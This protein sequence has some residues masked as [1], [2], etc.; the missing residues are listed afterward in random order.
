[1]LE[2]Q[3]TEYINI[4]EII[5]FVRQKDYKFVEKLSRGGCGTTILLKDEVINELF[6]CKKYDPFDPEK[7]LDSE[8]KEKLF[9]NFKEEI[10]LL[11]LV[12]NKNIVRVFNYHIYNEY[13]TGYII[14]EYVKGINI[15][16][17]LAWFPENINDV[18]L[19][20]VDGFTYLEK[21]NILHRDV[22]PQN[23]MVTNDGQVKIIDFGFG[24]QIKSNKDFDKS[25]SLNWWCEPPLDFKQKTY[26]FKTELYFVGKLFEQI[27]Q[28][29]NIETFKY[30]YELSNMCKTNPEERIDS[31]A[32]IKQ[33]ILENQFLELPFSQ[34]E[35]SIYLDFANHLSNVIS[36]IK[37]S[38][39]Y[40][41]DIDK[42]Q[43]K[44]EELFKKVMLENV[45][46]KN[47][48]IIDCFFKGGYSYWKR[49]D[50]PIDSL[51]K[52]IEMLR[53]SS[54]EKKNVILS[55]LH[56]RFNAIER[57]KEDLI[58]EDEIPF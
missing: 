43:S 34:E 40:Y 5:K 24:K 32:N 50:F 52:I 38:T 36:K 47:T 25:I 8:F 49:E 12:H 7:Q 6:V 28:E 17:Y 30:R 21:N 56:S 19:Q 20:V 16:E 27:I 44:L 58:G 42:I 1:M 18:F 57:E 48:Y 2:Q 4:P 26:D 3:N 9:E 55:N 11:H 31:F 41:D 33:G 13:L 15:T 23:I 35:K 45:L 46:P 29:N 39:E 22:R 53:S 10:K 37:N 14:M 51:K 54:K